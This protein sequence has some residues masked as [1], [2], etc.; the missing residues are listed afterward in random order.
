MVFICIP[1]W[2]I[3]KVLSASKFLCLCALEAIFFSS[4]LNQF[5]IW[6]S[7]K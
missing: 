4:E 2:A 6:L 1:I 3:A 5:L 7:F